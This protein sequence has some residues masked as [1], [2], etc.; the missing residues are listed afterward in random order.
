[1]TSSEGIAPVP[2]R[3]RKLLPPVLTPALIPRPRLHTALQR[4]NDVPFTLLIAPAGYGKTTLVRQWQAGQEGPGVWLTLDRDDI[5]PHRLVSHLL[6]A[7]QPV[8][9]LDPRTIGTAGSDSMSEIGGAIADALFDV[10]GKPFIILDDVHE[11]LSQALVALLTSLVRLLP[12]NVHLLV[13]SRRDVPASLARM[14]AQGQLLELRAADLRFT[15]D[16][17][18][19][20]VTLLAGD[21]ADPVVVDLLQEHT[22]GWITGLRLAIEAL[23]LARDSR[24]LARAASGQRHLMQY[25]VEEM[26]ASASPADQEFLIHT[27]IAHRLSVPL[28]EVLLPEAVPG[29]SQPR[30]ERLAQEH[31]FLEET[32]EPGWYR[33]QP[34]VQQ[35]LQTRLAT[36]AGAGTVHSLHELAGAWFAAQSMVADALPH[37]LATGSLD[38][39]AALIEHHMHDLFAREDWR[40]VASWLQQL[41]EDLVHERPGLLLARGMVVH[42]SGRAAPLRLLLSEAKAIAASSGASPSDM[43]ALHAEIDILGMATLLP[44]EQ[45]PERTSHVIAHALEY[46]PEHHRFFYGLALGMNGLALQ[47]LG[48]EREAISY[49]AAIAVFEAEYFDAAS[50]R[51]LLGL[52][53]VHRQTGS[54]NAGADICRHTLTI[55]A[56]DDLAVT[57]AWAHLFLGWNAYERDDLAVAQAQFSAVIGD[58]WHAH[59]SCVREAYFG[60]ALIHE[61]Q[62]RTAAADQDLTELADVIVENRALEHLPALHG[63]E[64]RIALMRGNL[65]V[66][67][68]WATTGD[69]SIDS[70]TL[71][72]FEHALV[73]RSRVLLAQGTPASLADALGCLMRLRERAVGAHHHARLVEIMALLALVHDALGDTDAALAAL[74]ESLAYAARGT[75]I[76]SYLDLGPDMIALLHR[77][78]PHLDLPLPLA[79]AIARTDPGIPLEPVPPA[80]IPSPLTT[81]SPREQDVL[82]LLAQ[83]LSYQEIAQRLFISA[84]TVKRHVS[85]IYSKLDVG[86]RRQALLKAESLGW[87]PFQ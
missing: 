81:L 47:A 7:L 65:R 34:L 61:V 40:T 11:A 59:L 70:N 55:T 25:L 82:E 12:P 23:P 6:A 64:A 2:I 30:L 62:G 26:L 71:F 63:F 73:T 10:E 45:D 29:A 80:P 28:A 79:Q 42:L 16:E 41:P 4:A 50:I 85:S 17:T 3:R 22:D 87:T 39:A 48:A 14:R 49:L 58:V 43:S 56:R 35:L 36:R 69:I 46:V 9:A 54:M 78:R 75:F 66:A 13:L 5:D 33:Y 67:Q 68:E 15:R 37:L 8:L 51:A 1:M 31:L 44:I 76:R 57:G 21:C 27:S 38:A 74:R 32:D 60:R 86:N 19:T 52:I 53:F 18:E 72:A 77:L 83:R 84:G 20:L 24:E